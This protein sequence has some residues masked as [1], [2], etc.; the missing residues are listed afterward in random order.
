MI[1]DRYYEENDGLR[2]VIDLIGS[3]FFSGG[4]KNLFR[5]L[6]DSL[7]T[8]DEYMLCADYQSYIECQHDITAAYRDI[9]R[10]LKMSIINVA[11]TGKF[12]SDRSILEYAG[13]I[14]KVTRSGHWNQ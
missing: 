1:L 14:W 5:P 7:L 3:G 13:K 4:D 11:R 10:W 2:E 12:S 6:I 9:H 8:Y